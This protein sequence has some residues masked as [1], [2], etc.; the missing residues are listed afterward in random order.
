MNLSTQTEVTV[1]KSR[2][3]YVASLA[4]YVLVNARDAQEALDLAKNHPLLKGRPI[5]VARPATGDEI[6]LQ[7]WADEQEMNNQVKE[8]P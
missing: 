2:S 1:E 5:L 4:Q 8:E 6:Q 3:Y 7:Q